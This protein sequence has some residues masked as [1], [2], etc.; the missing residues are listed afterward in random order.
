MARSINV[1][2]DDDLFMLN[3]NEEPCANGSI[4]FAMDGVAVF[5]KGSNSVGLDKSSEY[6]DRSSA[7]AMKRGSEMLGTMRRTGTVAEDKRVVKAIDACLK[8]DREKK[9]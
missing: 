3:I 5:N 1:K 9:V 2:I 6:Q 7:S 4:R 8:E